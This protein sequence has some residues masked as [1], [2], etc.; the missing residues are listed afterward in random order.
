M[1]DLKTYMSLTDAESASEITSI[2]T[3]N[4]IPFKIQDTGK[5]FDASFSM[6]KASKSILI[7]LHSNDFERANAVVDTELILDENTIDKEHFLYGFSN[8]ELLDV[9]KNSEE[10]HPLDVKL[11][12]QLLEQNKIQ[13]NETEIADFK[14]E[15]VAESFKPEKSDITTI[16]IGYVFSITGGLIGLGITFF[17]I[18]SKKTLPTGEKIYT[19]CKSDRSHGFKMLILSSI[20]IVICLIVV[21]KK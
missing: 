5:D 12:K 7:L 13:I 20:S 10:W 19:Y 17:L 9:I 1:S 6:N 16:L 21:L 18:N 3:K 15:K 2:L 14:K 11:A 8:D 4:K